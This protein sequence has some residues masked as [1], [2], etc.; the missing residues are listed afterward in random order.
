MLL[1]RITDNTATL[2]HSY[3]CITHNIH[4]M[5]VFDFVSR[6]LVKA[7]F[8]QESSS[9]NSPYSFNGEV[10]RT[11]FQ[12]LAQTAAVTDLS[13]KSHPKSLFFVYVL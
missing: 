10:V 3:D 11:L 5:V 4:N 9:Q 13:L 1:R 7:H 2:Q 6:A 12:P 8:S